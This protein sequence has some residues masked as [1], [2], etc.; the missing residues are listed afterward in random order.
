MSKSK[1]SQS[2]GN[3]CYPHVVFA[4]HKIFQVMSLKLQ[5]IKKTTPVAFKTLTVSEESERT[6]PEIT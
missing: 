3:E 5:C 6:I 2:E 4:S 1:N